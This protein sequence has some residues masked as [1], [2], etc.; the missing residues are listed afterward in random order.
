MT[1]L[2]PVVR[3]GEPGPD[4]P[5]LCVRAAAG[6]R[7]LVEGAGD[8]LLVGR[9]E[10]DWAGATVAYPPGRGSPG[11]LPPWTAA[12][13]R[14]L[15]AEP[16]RW[17][18][19]VR[20]RLRAAPLSPL[21]TG[22]WVL[23]A[24]PSPWR[25][26]SAFRRDA[27]RWLA[28]ECAVPAVDADGSVTADVDY[29]RQTAAGGTALIPL[30]ALADADS[31]RVKA[32]RRLARDGA[33][34]PVV[35]LHV[36]GLAGHLVLDG[37]DR[38]VAARAEGVVPSFACLA[39]TDADEDAATVDDA[40]GAYGQAM[41]LLDDLDAV[42]G[43]LAAGDVQ[44]ARAARRLAADLGAVHA[45]LTRAWPVTVE[46][47]EAAARGIGAARISDDAAT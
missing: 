27:P 15:G 4:V 9:V 24:Y 35:L 10:R 23:T 2:D 1:P 11:V 13:C 38:L 21:H 26:A 34:A 43:R 16:G 17:L 20:D 41:T 39:R 40:V 31:P 30:H 5:T 7:L 37:H 12:E 8:V 19:A 18:H 32:H 46:A 3:W 47:W 14:A 25:D 36:S 28:D 22:S 6:G 42:P 45:A 44:R 29:V 33:L